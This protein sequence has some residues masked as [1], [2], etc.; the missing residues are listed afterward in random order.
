MAKRTADSFRPER[1]Y[2]LNKVRDEEVT[3]RVLESPEMDG[4]PV[5]YVDKFG[6]FRDREFQEIGPGNL[7]EL[8]PANIL[9]G[10]SLLYIRSSA[11]NPVVEEQGW[12]D[13]VSMDVF[14]QDGARLFNVKLGGMCVF[15]CQY[16]YMYG[17]NPHTPPVAIN[18]DVPIVQRKMAQIVEESGGRPCTFNLGEHTDSLALDYLTRMTTDF[19]PFVTTLPNSQLELRTK[20][21]NVQNLKGLDH[22]GRTIVGFTLSPQ[23]VI[24]KSE[25]DNAVPVEDRIEAVRQC[26]EWGYPVSLKID[27][28]I[29]F[30]G[31]QDAYTDLV[32]RLAEPLDPK[33]VHHYAIGV[34][35]WSTKNLNLCRAMFPDS[36]LWGF[37]YPDIQSGK[38]AP[39]EEERRE[40]YLHVLPRMQAA[41]P[42]VKYY[43]SM[44]MKDFA[45][46][47]EAETATVEIPA[48]ASIQN[49]GKTL[50][51]QDGGLTIRHLHYV[52]VPPSSDDEQNSSY[53]VDIQ[54]DPSKLNT[55]LFGVVELL[56]DE[57]PKP[58]DFVSNTIEEIS[59]FVRNRMLAIEDVFDVGTIITIALRK[60]HVLED[61]LV[62]GSHPIRE[63]VNKEGMLYWI[64]IGQ[65]G[66]FSL[67]AKVVQD[68]DDKIGKLRTNLEDIPLRKY[69]ADQAKALIQTDPVRE[70]DYRPVM[71]LEMAARYLAISESTLYKVDKKL[72]PRT[73]QGRFRKKDLDEYLEKTMKRR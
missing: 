37:D 67:Q 41:F 66:V 39:S 7:F 10:R 30:E 5:E 36:K 57:N 16:C 32:D 35:R 2:V 40:I 45:D 59:P 3:R 38:L 6:D 14:K 33:L 17:A 63:L 68:K 60:G 62:D 12:D 54:V 22:Q 47:I 31:W 25:G 49:E 51:R 11:G 58:T 61:I 18:A 69:L 52:D 26:Q 55:P 23:L 13:R 15:K 65:S 8:A 19:I 29:P 21:A 4:I 53:R 43:L 20:S 73:A 1:I 50:V 46:I 34:L 71:D 42:D 70:E 56:Y 44:E 28:I 9:L 24:D 48:R 72:L 27:P 64:R